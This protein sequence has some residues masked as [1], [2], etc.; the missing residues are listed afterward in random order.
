MLEQL[1]FD[2]EKSLRSKS[3]ILPMKYETNT[4]TT[5]KGSGKLLLYYFLLLITQ[6]ETISRL[7]KQYTVR[8]G[9]SRVLSCALVM[10]P[11]LAWR[12]KPAEKCGQ[13]MRATLD[14]IHATVVNK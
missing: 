6:C 7:Q 14:M 5:K 10:E 13:S 2:L 9:N 12:K 3:N 1:T 11:A 4:P 8:H